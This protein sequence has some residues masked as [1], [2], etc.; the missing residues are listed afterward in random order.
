MSDIVF[1]IVLSERYCI[2]ITKHIMKDEKVIKSATGQMQMGGY[3]KTKTL[4]L[5][6]SNDYYR[7]RWKGDNVEDITK[8]K[9]KALD[10]FDSKSKELEAA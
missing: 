1:I 2:D 6:F 5:T 4:E 9:S 10:W 7:L 8:D 3:F